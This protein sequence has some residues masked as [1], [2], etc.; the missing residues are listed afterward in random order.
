[1]EEQQKILIMKTEASTREVQIEEKTS[2]WEKI[3]DWQNR[4][5]KQSQDFIDHSRHMNGCGSRKVL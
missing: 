5:G 2:T 4:T 3:L 1:M